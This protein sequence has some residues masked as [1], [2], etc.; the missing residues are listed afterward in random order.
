MANVLLMPKLGLTME[1]GTIIEWYIGEG[2]S[3]E[4]GDIIYSVETEKL[5]NDVEATTSGE[6]LEILV[7]EGETVEVKTPVAKLVGYEEGDAEIKA[8]AEEEKKKKKKLSQ[9][10]QQK[11]K[12]LLLEK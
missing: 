9:K 2:D 10:L 1:K 7:N 4:Q 12:N 6:I 11:R 3:F 8:A 5:T